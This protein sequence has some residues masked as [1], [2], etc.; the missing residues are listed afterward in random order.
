MSCYLSLL[1]NLLQKLICQQLICFAYARRQRSRQ[2]SMFGRP[3]PT[4][5]RTPP[6]T[7]TK[8]RP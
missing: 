5:E 3:W 2:G 4:R 6:T 1:P 7:R 8:H